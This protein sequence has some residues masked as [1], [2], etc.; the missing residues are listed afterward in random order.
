MVQLA[1]AMKKAI[2]MQTL[3]VCLDH[4]HRNEAK[5]FSIQ[6]VSVVCFKSLRSHF[7]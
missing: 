2:E 7:D 3:K 1:L 4:T 5:N 6:E